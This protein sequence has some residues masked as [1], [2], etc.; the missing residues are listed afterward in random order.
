MLLDLL[1]VSTSLL[2]L[3]QA[4]VTLVGLIS[5]QKKWPTSLGL[6]SKSSPQPS[7]TGV[8]VTSPV[9]FRSPT[10]QMSSSASPSARYLPATREWSLRDATTASELRLTEAELAY[11]VAQKTMSNPAV[12]GQFYRELNEAKRDYGKSSRTANRSH[13]LSEQ[14]EYLSPDVRRQGYHFE[15]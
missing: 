8:R 1:Y 15:R 12:V 14:A 10:T 2:T 4:T 5:G 7:S 6:R 11:R 9:I 3:Y 13:L